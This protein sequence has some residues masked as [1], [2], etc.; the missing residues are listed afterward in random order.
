MDFI[1]PEVSK[2]IRRGPVYVVHGLLLM[3]L[4]SAG[5]VAPVMQ[6]DHERMLYPA[7]VA[8]STMFVW[9]LA[10]WYWLRRTLFEPYPL[11]IL[12]AA[13]FNAGQAFLEVFGMNPNGMLKG[14]VS[15]EVLT[16]ALYQ[17]AVSVAFLHAGALAATARR[18][19]DDDEVL[20]DRRQKASRIAG[21]CLLAAAIVP[22]IVLFRSSFSLVMDFGYMSLFRNLNTMS[23]TLAISSFFVPG[24][25]FLLAGARNKR[26]IQMFCLTATACYA[27]AYLFMGAR[28]SAAMCCVAVAWVF[29]RSIRRI[30]RPVILTMGLVAM[31]IFPLVRETRGTGG[32]YRMSLEDQLETLGNL[33]NPI[34]SSVSEMGHSLVTVTHT[35]TL[36]P[37]SRPF[38]YGASYLYALTAV[39]PNVGWAVHPSVAH[40]L[41]SEWLVKTVDPFIAAAGGGLGFS[42]IAEAYLNFGW[43]GGPLW[44]GVVGFAL[45][46]LFLKAD[47]GDP[48]RQALAASFLSFFFV[49]ARGE[50]AIVARGLVWYAVF[51]YLLAVAV[52]IRS[53]KRGQ[54]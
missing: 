20:G 48:A 18:K 1:R 33:E 42:F 46:W 22:T 45:S 35:L 37:E 28:G 36:V 2:N 30:P 38:D 29:D 4:I 8:V 49:F 9:M 23:T 26:G 51:P 6:L 41:L 43:Y 12:S 53:R 50:A 5:L 27:G 32:R 3:L 11:F 39:I 7:C 19:A 24:V 44:L 52:T 34:S 31:L 47:G 54:A 21:W 15:P 25:I 40:G 16:P 10:S 17:V 13:L 14:R